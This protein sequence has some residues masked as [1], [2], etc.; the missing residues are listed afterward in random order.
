MDGP[1][2][3]FAPRL[4]DSGVE[5]VEVGPRDGFQPIGPW[6][7]TERKIDF[8]Q[9]VA[10]AGVR[11]IEITSFASEAA[12]PQLRDAGEVLAAALKIDGLTAQVLV[13]TARRGRQAVAAGATAI[14]Y[15]LSVSQA[16]NLSNVRRTVAESIDDY[17]AFASGLDRGI[18]LRVN[19]ATAFDC[20]FTGQV[21]RDAVLGTLQAL[22][23][24]RQDVEVCLCDTTG[25]A[26]PARVRELFT[27][28]ATRFPDV[29]RWAFHGHDTYG[30]GCANSYA[31][32]VAGV[33]VVDGAFGGLGGCPFA[34]GATGN[35][36]TEDLV[37]M[38]ERMQVATGIDLAAFVP[39]ASDAAGITGASAGGRVRTALDA[40]RCLAAGAPPGLSPP[41]GRP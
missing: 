30:L 1:H 3:A 5:I 2:A 39:I 38:F 20:P 9:R 18:G 15:V 40:A 26:D 27:E 21:A 34:P 11:R 7:P 23:A 32:Y 10:A 14:A 37:W 41:V 31:A 36:A 24:V 33:R 35:T 19:L 17:S 12:I 8:V 16:H 28:V 4:P 13:P 29:S 22:V 25:R 6:I